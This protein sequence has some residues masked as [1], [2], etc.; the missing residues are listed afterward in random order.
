[1]SQRSE[2]TLTALAIEAAPVIGVFEPRCS[3]ELTKESLKS[4]TEDL[5]LNTENIIDVETIQTQHLTFNIREGD[6]IFL[7]VLFG[8]T[9]T[10]LTLLSDRP[11]SYHQRLSRDQG[12]SPKQK[13]Y[14]G[15]AQLD[16]KIDADS[17]IQIIQ[18]KL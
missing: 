12:S 14:S 15:P 13:L 11:Q 7:R 17:Y 18:G 2:A 9:G 16:L 3:V 5:S 1:M 8:A 6:F 4:I 10:N